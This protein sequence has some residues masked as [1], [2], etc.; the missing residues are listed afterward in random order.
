MLLVHCLFILHALLFV[1]FFSSLCWG[2]TAAFDCGY[3]W[4]FHLT[5]LKFYC[6]IV[7]DNYRCVVVMIFD[8]PYCQSMNQLKV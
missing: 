4:T 3:S 7:D 8:P 2:L 6:H 1:F 5:F